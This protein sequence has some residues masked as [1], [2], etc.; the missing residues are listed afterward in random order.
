L[1]SAANETP[2]VCPPK[3]LLNVQMFISKAK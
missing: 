2:C 1:R 3:R